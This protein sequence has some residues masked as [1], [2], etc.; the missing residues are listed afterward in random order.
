MHFVYN[1]TLSV[2]S[3]NG[4]DIEPSTCVRVS[5][6]PS[7]VRFRQRAYGHEERILHSRLQ[8]SCGFLKGEVYLLVCS[9]RL[10]VLSSSKI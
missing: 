8:K 3:G 10:A 9:V 4:K 2:F 1:S 5:A 6:H 7:A